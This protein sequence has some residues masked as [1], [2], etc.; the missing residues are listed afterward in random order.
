M[1]A[2]SLKK[3][4]RFFKKFLNFLKCLKKIPEVQL[5]GKY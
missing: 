1:N 2:L 5:L 4:K 3:R